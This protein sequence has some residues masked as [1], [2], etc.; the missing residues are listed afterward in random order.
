LIKDLKTFEYYKNQEAYLK[1]A[2]LL[3]NAA[4]FNN[5]AK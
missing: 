4:D 1:Q 2:K 5:L 3:E